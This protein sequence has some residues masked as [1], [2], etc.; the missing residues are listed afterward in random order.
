MPGVQVAMTLE[1]CWHA[2]PGGTA[3]STLELVRALIARDDVE[4]IGV[5]ARHRHPPPAPWTPPVVV[6]QLPLPRQVLYETWH[7]PMSRWP[8]VERATG[9]VDVV[10]ATAVAFPPAIAPVVVTIHDLAFLHDPRLA[11]RHG[12]RFFRRGLELARRHAR[13]VMCPSQATIDECIDAGLDRDRLRLVPWGVAPSTVTMDDVRPIL[14][15]YSIDRPYVLFAGTV[16]PRKNLPRLLEAFARVPNDV[17]L[18]LVGPSGWNESIDAQL[19]ALGSRVRTLG[20]LGRGEL[21]ALLAGASVFCYPSL[22][23]GFGLPVLEAMAQGTP[24]VT[25]NSTST[26][27]IAGDAGILVDP[28][29]VDAIAGAIRSLLDDRPEAR[30]LGDK[31]RQRAREFTWER[32]ADLVAGVYAEAVVSSPGG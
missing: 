28:V 6:K 17:D 26:A 29:D 5:S 15:R 9:P 23:E 27:E 14:D 19:G 32:T 31:G 20:F 22:R 11:T 30:R 1:Q 7:A 12:H 4:V 18:V 25:S 24:V 3:W 10:H 13:L 16:E 8:K 21:D 2:V